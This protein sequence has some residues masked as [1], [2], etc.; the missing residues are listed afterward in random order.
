MRRMKMKK[1]FK[2]SVLLKAAGLCL[3]LFILGFFA[4]GAA[5]KLMKGVNFAD[6]FKVDHLVAGITLTVIQT[7][8]TIGGL[9]A[10]ALIL[11][12]T[13]K[14]AELWD[15]EDED[16]IDDIEE[17]LNYPVL[18]CSTVMILDIMLFSCA[19][20]FLP[21]ESVFWDVLSVAVFLIG[22]IFCSVINEKTIIVEKKLNPEKKGSSFDLKFVKKWMDSSDEA[23]KQIVWQAGYNAY[24]AGNTACMVI[25]II[26]FPLQVLFK[27]GILPVVSVGII[28]LIMNTA[29]VQSAA[30]LSRRR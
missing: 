19:V 6:L 5:G 10:A 23:E 22:M 24:K 1:K 29:Y 21:K 17:K 4:G 15:G 9:L 16:E 11:S 14:R 7:V 8:V 28:W 30:K 2:N 27:T 13:S 12:K 20:Y 18:L 25:W 3:G 26:V